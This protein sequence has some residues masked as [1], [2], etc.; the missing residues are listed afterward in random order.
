MDQG[1]DDVSVHWGAKSPSVAATG[2]DKRITVRVFLLLLVFGAIYR[3]ISSVGRQWYFE[4]S[5]ASSSRNISFREDDGCSES[6]A[7]NNIHWSPY[8]TLE[9]ATLEVIRNCIYHKLGVRPPEEPLTRKDVPKMTLRCPHTDGK[10]RLP[11][12]SSPDLDLSELSRI[13]RSALG[14]FRTVWYFGDSVCRQSYWTTVCLADP[15]ADP[16]RV[17]GKFDGQK[18]A[19]DVSYPLE[20]LNTTLRFIDH[21][22]TKDYSI[23]LKKLSLGSGDAVVIN[24]GAR[25]DERSVSNL[26]NAYRDISA[27]SRTYPSV[28]IFFLETTDAQWPTS[29]GLFLDRLRW[30]IPQCEPVTDDRLMAM[31]S[32]SV[33]ASELASWFASIGRSFEPSLEQ[34]SILPNVTR[35]RYYKAFASNRRNGSSTCV[36]HCLPANWRNELLQ[37]LMKKD[38]SRT[39]DVVPLFYQ[40]I[41]SETPHMLTDGD[42]MHKGTDILITAAKQLIRI[43]SLN[44]L[45]SRS[46]T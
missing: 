6:I 5:D 22:G 20:N 23:P 3:E 44:S 18:R 45:S 10:A 14:K 43:M 15:M 26:A 27:L 12:L 25:F 46:V 29:N 40:L 9:N 1:A 39:V 4:L 17:Y 2:R 11:I 7:S 13:F 31:G 32:V 16:S 37:S 42:C 28:P 35:A 34:L 19:L 33:E 30:K 24:A 38:G 8:S 36:P 21:G 41:A